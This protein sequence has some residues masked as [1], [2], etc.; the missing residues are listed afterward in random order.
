MNSKPLKTLAIAAVIVAVGGLTLGY[1]ALTQT[2]NISTE[3]KVQNTATSWKVKF[4]NPSSGTATGDAVKGTIT[5]NDTTATLTGVVL[6][7]PGDSVTYTFD[8]TNA[9]Q[10]DAKLSSVTMKT[11]TVTGTGSS[12]SADK[13]LVEGNYT[14]ALTYNDGTAISQ[15]DALGAGAT[16]TIKLVV[17]YKS[18]ATS[19]PAGDVTISGLGATLTYAQA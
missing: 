11:P 7:A 4:N 13:T 8:V 14:Y 3:A 19:L 15:N 9:G 18:S 6:K 16:K 17:T 10:I 5:V 1:A 12:A 2:L